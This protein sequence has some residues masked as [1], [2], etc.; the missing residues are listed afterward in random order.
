MTLHDAA[1]P[2][3]VIP[4]TQQKQTKTECTFNQALYIKV[5]TGKT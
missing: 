3:I 1:F 2:T 4:A 5:A